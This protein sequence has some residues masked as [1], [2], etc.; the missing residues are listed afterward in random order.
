L[1]ESLRQSWSHDRAAWIVSTALSVALYVA[2]ALAIPVALARIPVDYFT[3][4]P[5]RP[6]VAVR[7][8]RVVGGLVVTAAGVAMLFLPGPGVLTILLG[9]SIVGGDL[10]ARGVRALVGRPGVL[11]AINKIRERRGRAPLAP[12]GASPHDWA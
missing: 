5:H 1:F 9:L 4:P 7:V 8:L 6:G 12:P 10:A 11:A 2:I 3:R